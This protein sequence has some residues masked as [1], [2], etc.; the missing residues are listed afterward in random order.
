MPLVFVHGVTVRKDAEYLQS[1]KIRDG[2]FRSLALAGVVNDPSNCL[3][4]NPYWGEYGA[5]LAWNGASLPEG[6]IE[7]FG[8][9]SDKIAGLLAEVAP[10]VAP[11]SADKLLKSLAANS[12]LRAV[13][14][15][16]AA[17]VLTMSSGDFV[18]D[19]PKLA[20]RAIEYAETKHDLTWLDTVVN[21]TEFVDKLLVELDAWASPTS[22]IEQFG[23]GD[24]LNNLKTAAINIGQ[25]AAAR[26]VSAGQAATALVINPLAEA[27]RPW[28]NAKASLFLGDV[29]V[30]LKSRKSTSGGDIVEV[31]GSAFHEAS[32]R[33]DAVADQLIVVGHSM[34]GNIAYDV[35]TSFTP[36][37]TVDL[38]L[39]VGSQVGLFEELKLF[40]SSDKSIRS[41]SKVNKPKNI[42]RWI[43]VMD[44]GDILAYST[45]PIF[46]DSIDTNF[47]TKVPT[48]GAH[49]AYFYRPL[50]HR[51]LNARLITEAEN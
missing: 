12:I 22:G 45:S 3:I 46:E 10:D 2:L 4:L 40:S 37:V 42:L 17:G 16:F 34:G 23:V 51:R 31:V 30:Y 21:D 50:F 20:A 47:D 18:E 19:F 15:L 41:P 48:W 24:L 9:D 6:K 35:L 11:P 26:T 33:R 39:T 25:A 8:S 49:S 13:D 32:K 43:N 28:L 36:M 27:G 5:S 38:F 14:C 44:P 7:S 1:E 29:L